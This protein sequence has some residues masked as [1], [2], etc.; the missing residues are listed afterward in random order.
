MHSRLIAFLVVLLLFWSGF[1][2]SGWSQPHVGSGPAL[3][4]ATAPDTVTPARPLG[5]AEHHQPT[6]LQAQAEP[7]SDVEGAALLSPPPADQAPAL[8]LSRPIRFESAAVCAPFL[9]GPLRPP[10]AVGSHA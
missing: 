5:S 9:D 10:C 6:S 8:A 3:A 7:L 4:H 1:G 2:S